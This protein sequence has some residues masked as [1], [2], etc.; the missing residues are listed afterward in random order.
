MSKRTHTAKQGKPA[1]TAREFEAL[2]DSEKERIYQEIDQADPERLRAESKPLTA[3]DRERWNRFKKKAGR[4]KVGQ[5]VRVIS[6]S[7]ER[8]L[9]KEAD[10]FAK[11]NGTSRAELV[12]RALR[13]ILVFPEREKAAAPPA[14]WIPIS[15]SGSRLDA[16][17]A[18]GT[19][20][21]ASSSPARR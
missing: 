17:T 6:L 16:S 13:S 21:A 9:L 20:A 7:V 14:E 19:P 12:A 2:P 10:A 1:M 3:I 5:G 18:R 4:P 8:G 11:R 15:T